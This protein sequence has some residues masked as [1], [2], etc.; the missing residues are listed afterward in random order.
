MLVSFRTLR[1]IPILLAACLV[2]V[3]MGVVDGARCGHADY[4]GMPA[5]CCDG[6]ASPV[7]Q[8][9]AE[10]CHTVAENAG[11]AAG[12]ACACHIGQ[13]VPV[14]EAAQ[15][16]ATAPVAAAPARMVVLVPPSPRLDFNHAPRPPGPDDAGAPA[17]FLLF[18]VFLI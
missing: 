1:L 18:S 7:Q 3:G 15:N 11:T 4:T 9:P 8:P 12:E 13:H 16:V 10:P 14:E 6:H 17:R 2:L 5:P